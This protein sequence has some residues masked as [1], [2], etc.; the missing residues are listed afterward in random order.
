MTFDFTSKGKVRVTMQRLVD[1]I[2][3]GCGVTVERKTPAAEHLFDINPMAEKLQGK[4]KEYFRSYTAKL[5]YVGKR[6]KPEMLTAISF[7]TTRANSP[8]VDDLAKLQRA[9]GYLLYT[10]DRGIVLEIGDTITVNAFVDAAYGV[11]STSGKSHSGCAI[12]LGTGGPVHVKSTKQKLV[13][14]SSTE[15][16][17]V[18]LSDYASQTVWM[19][20]FIVQQGYEVGPV[21]LHQDNM[22]CMAIVKRGGPA[23]ERSRHINIRYFWVKQL[24]DG[25]VAIVKHLPTDKM[26]VNIMTK[27]VQGQQFVQE[28]NALTNWK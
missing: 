10:R 21:I 26:Y 18:A 19:R 2:I 1:E 23:S 14:K 12:V 22:S 15:A 24:V 9:L 13:T 3:A 7:L 27:P 20:N 6:V 25:K 11:H 4:D 8:D 17:L 16:E 5:L 28:R